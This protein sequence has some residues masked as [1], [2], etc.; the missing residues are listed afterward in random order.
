M[1]FVRVWR[2]LDA[3][4]GRATSGA[5]PRCERRSAGALDFW[6]VLLRGVF[7]LDCFR[8]NG[9]AAGT[10]RCRSASRPRFAYFPFG[11]GSRICI[12]NNFAMMETQLVLATLAQHYR[13]ELV[14]GHTVVPDPTFA[15]KPRYGVLVKPHLV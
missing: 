5:L 3:R 4:G 10:S 15:L 8:S 1:V 13:L 11:G 9:A 6:Y 14:S 7:Q 12:G 2:S